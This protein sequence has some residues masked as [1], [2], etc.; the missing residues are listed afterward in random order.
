MNLKEKLESI[1]Q[2]QLLRFESELSDAQKKALYE[3]IE[4]I[5]FS[6][7]DELKNRG[8]GLKRGKI[9]PLEALDLEKLFDLCCCSCRFIED[10]NTFAI[11]Y[12]CKFAYPNSSTR[13]Q[14]III[15]GK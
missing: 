2:S 5:D 14:S 13:C 4:S 11:F 3:Q 10:F 1:G 12:L 6:V 8:K 7:L 9:T 15:K